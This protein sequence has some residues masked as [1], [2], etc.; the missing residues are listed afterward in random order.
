MD[1]VSGYDVVIDGSD[2]FPTRYL[3][4][5][6]CVF[7]GKPNIYG[8]VFRFDGQATSSRR[9]SAAPVIAVFS[10]AAAGRHGSELRRS[11]RAR[12]APGIVGTHA[13]A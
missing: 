11:G 4:S 8:S 12:R 1:L 3:S 2:N 9:I 6:V 5:D 13:G 7:A 10:R